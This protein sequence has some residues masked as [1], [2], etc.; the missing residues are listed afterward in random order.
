LLPDSHEIVFCCP[1]LNFEDQAN[2]LPVME[3]FVR[4]PVDDDVIHQEP[5]SDVQEPPANLES[6]FPELEHSFAEDLDGA[7][8]SLGSMGVHEISD[9]SQDEEQVIFVYSSMSH[10]FL[11]LLWSELVFSERILYIESKVMSSCSGI[12][13][14]GARGICQ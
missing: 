5:I 14:P 8:Q 7:H 1:D 11:D 3:D 2:D 9:D 12:F 4:G 10:L 13:Y 6:A